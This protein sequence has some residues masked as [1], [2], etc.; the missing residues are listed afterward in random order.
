MYGQA[1]C[2]GI[3]SS[4]FTC[5]CQQGTFSCFQTVECNFVCPDS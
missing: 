5:Q 3:P 1:S 2:C 4:A